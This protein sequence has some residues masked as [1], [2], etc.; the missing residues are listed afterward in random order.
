[1]R[2]HA[3]GDGDVRYH[4]RMRERCPSN[5]DACG[6]IPAEIVLA[7]QSPRRRR[8]L[9]CLGLP[10]VVTSVDTLEDLNTPLASDPEALARHL[11][12]EKARAAHEDGHAQSGLVMCFDTIVVLDGAVLGKP[13]DVADAWRML[14][15]LSGRTHAVVTGV[16]LLCPDDTEPRTFAV[17][18]E[19]AMKSLSDADIEEWMA[20]GEFMGCAGAY[21]IEGQIAD[22]TEDEC[23][24]NVAGLPLCHLYA[25]LTSCRPACLP[26]EPRAPIAECDAMLG[27]LCRLGPRVCSSE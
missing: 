24:Q 4:L 27:R 21:N 20:R 12:A 16:A 19:V 26:A 17:T 14:R 3:Q 25:E 8:L 2:A 10:F 6:A 1:L 23:Y 5:S 18:T 11:A 9:G 22:V 13:V 15:S 7:S